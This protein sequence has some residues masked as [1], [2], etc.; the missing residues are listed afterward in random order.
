MTDEEVLRH[1]LN[2]NLCR[3]ALFHA[4]CAYIGDMLHLQHRFQESFTVHEQPW[5]LPSHASPSVVFHHE[6]YQKKSTGPS[7][8]TAAENYLALIA[9]TNYHFLRQAV[10]D[11]AKYYAG[12]N[13]VDAVLDQRETGLRDVDLTI[14]SETI[15]TFVRLHDLRVRDMI[16]TATSATGDLAS[17]GTTNDQHGWPFDVFE[18]V[19]DD[20]NAQAFFDDYMFNG[21]PA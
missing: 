21:K 3:Q 9:K 12:A 18:E 7:R 11:M 16:P 17:S 13:W 15:S 1:L 5:P 20:F 2:Y 19:P 6:D 14:A 4:S 8:P 10:K